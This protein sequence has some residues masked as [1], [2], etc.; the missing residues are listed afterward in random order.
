MMC[1]CIPLHTMLHVVAGDDYLTVD[2]ATLLFDH[3]TTSS[4]FPVDIL[5]DNLTELIEIFEAIITGVD[6]FNVIGLQ[7]LSNQERCRVQFSPE[8]AQVNINDCEFNC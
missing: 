7:M 1:H 3:A 5:S 8:Q 4:N 6:V 2:A